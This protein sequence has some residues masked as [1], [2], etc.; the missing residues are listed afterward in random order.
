MII[1]FGECSVPVSGFVLGVAKLVKSFSDRG[2]AA[3]AGGCLC[4]AAAF[5][6]LR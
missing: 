6:S 1:S 5:Y 3:D 4:A 2:C